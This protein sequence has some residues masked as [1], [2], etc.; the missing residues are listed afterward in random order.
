[1]KSQRDFLDQ[2]RYLI[3][4]SGITSYRIAKDCGIESASLSRFVNGK[5]GLSMENLDK[6][7]KYLGLTITTKRK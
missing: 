3:T 2:L 6:L 5:G 1:M 4:H 7:G